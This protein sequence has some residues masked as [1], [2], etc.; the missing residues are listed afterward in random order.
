[1]KIFQYTALSDN[2]N[3]IVFCEKTGFC[4]GID[5]FNTEGFFDFVTKN[6]LK[7]IAILNTHHHNDHC[8][9]NQEIVKKYPEIDIYASQ[10]DYENKRIPFQTKVVNENDEIVIGEIKLKVLETKGHTLGHLAYYNEEAIF[11][12]DTLFSSGCGRLFEGTYS[13]MLDS[14]KKI[15]AHT[16]KN[17]KIYCGHEYTLSNLN[18]STS[19]NEKYFEE[20][21]IEIKD[22]RSNNIPSVPFFIDEQLSYNP[23]LMVFDENLKDQVLNYS[24]YSELEA[25]TDLRK[26]K[27]VF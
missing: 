5:I 24:N 7:P 3:W 15:I 25:F 9:G 16:K 13:Q 27:D 26:R 17:T 6:N 8:G 10:Y 19:L 21:L 12:G 18:F 11:V 1:M 23:F 14:M 20:K 2:Y 22:K 4:A